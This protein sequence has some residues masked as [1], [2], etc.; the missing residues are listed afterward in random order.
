MYPAGTLFRGLSRVMESAED[1]CRELNFWEMDTPC[2]RSA[3]LLARSILERWDL[4]GEDD[5]A[6]DIVPSA[7]K[8]AFNIVLSLQADA[9]RYFHDS[10]ARGLDVAR[11][12]FLKLAELVFDYIAFDVEKRG[13][14]KELLLRAREL[15]VLCES[16]A[17]LYPLFEKSP[18]LCKDR[19][20]GSVVGFDREEYDFFCFTNRAF[21]LLPKILKLYK[22]WVLSDLYRLDELTSEEEEDETEG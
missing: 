6:S 8:S 9:Y 3:L 18:A 11:Y 22:A 20:S 21:S 7:L 15:L 19:E 1:A 2:T 4:Y 10:S 16:Y 17:H 5:D 14:N 12:D 13:S